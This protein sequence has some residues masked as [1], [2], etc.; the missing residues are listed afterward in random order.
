M[1]HFFNSLAYETKQAYLS[2]KQKPLFVFSVVSTM[3]ITLGAL[4]CV[5][6]LAYVML[7]KPLPYPEQ[8][9]LYMAEH[10]LNDADGVNRA[11]AF[12][13]PGLVNFYDKQATFEQSA[14]LVFS[15]DVLTSNAQQPMKNTTYITPEYFSLLDTPMALGRKL[16]KEEGKGSF[17]PVAII[18]YQMWQNDFDG[19]TDVLNKKLMFNQVS[20]KIIGVTAANFIEPEL[21][22]IGRKTQVWL[23]WDYNT[24]GALYQNS[25]GSVRYELAFVGKLPI[26][27]SEAQAKQAISPFLNELW[28]SNVTELDFYQGWQVVM[29]LKSFKSV[30]LGDSKQRLYLLLAS[31]VG[32]LLIACANISNLFISRM[33][34]RQKTLAIRAAVGTTKKQL[35]ISLLVESLILM[36]YSMAIALIIS[37]LGFFLLQSQLSLFLPRISELSLNLFTLSSALFL[38]CLFA[39]FLAKLS[40]KMIDYQ[41][42]NHNLQSSAKGSGIQVSKRIRQVLIISQVAIASSLVFI[43]IN[44]FDDAI[45]DIATPAGYDSDNVVAIKLSADATLPR[46]SDESI[47]LLK[48]IRTQFNDLPQVS[49]VSQAAT[50]MSSNTSTLTNIATNKN[51]DVEVL[52]GIDKTYFNLLNI[53]LLTG[54]L[55]TDEDIQAN[56]RI[57]I[58]ND[59]LAKKLG[60][61]NNVIGKKI[62]IHGESIE[63]TIVGIVKGVNIPNVAS[64][65]MQAYRPT[66]RAS[67]SMLLKLN[68]GMS[69][70][71]EQVVSTINSVTS[72]F[73][74]FEINSL[75]NIRK[76]LLFSQY[77]TVITTSALTLLTL[78]LAAI[79]L[80]GVLNYST[81]MRRF[82]IGTRMA[83]GAKRSDLIKLIIKDNTHAILLGMGISVL[84]ISALA[85]GFSEQLQSY[86][87][88]QLIP[89]F[90]IT[91]GLVSLISFAACYLP[92][93]QYINKPAVY[94][95]RGSE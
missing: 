23:P 36:V 34:E 50:P 83:I 1:K 15:T 25:W 16:S 17:N 35:F 47:A 11:G 10:N 57:I 66:W 78:F 6:T 76:Q 9:K 73:T 88:W 93:R 61:V 46:G 87:T 68:K 26:N 2:L 72:K 22:E 40:N 92:L 28:Q 71:R 52:G 95:L 13:Y 33:A 21:A 27:T 39:L 48:A 45:T 79:G 89:L 58:I 49:I 18:S 38:M 80:Y 81:Q 8:D 90:L 7:I 19:N 64:E 59:T 53:T 20:F 74:L 94:S 5:L 30:I 82:E 60:D 75:S 54:D 32:L 77:T 24:L 86:L 62:K 12:T 56:N 44:L 4:L 29:D 37:W 41:A 84:L 43:N 31:I 63:R 3:G 14:M 67:S 55:F 70:S 65:P 42:L 51:Y 85:L 69:L 91:L